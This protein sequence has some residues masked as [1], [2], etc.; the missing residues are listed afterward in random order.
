M[1]QWGKRILFWCLV[2][3]AVALILGP[4]GWGALIIKNPIEAGIIALVFAAV[5]V[6]IG[7]LYEEYQRH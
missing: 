4:T 6:V 1:D 5:V 2:A 3:A 7:R